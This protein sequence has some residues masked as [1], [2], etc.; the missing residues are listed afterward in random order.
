MIIHSGSRPQLLL[1]RPMRG[2]G[3]PMQADLHPQVLM[4]ELER[5][6]QGPSP[7][8]LTALLQTRDEGTPL[9]LISTQNDLSARLQ[10]ARTGCGIYLPYPV[11]LEAFAH[12]LDCYLD[13]PPP[14]PER[15]L[16]VEDSPVQATYLGT[17]L[18]EAGMETCLVTDPEQALDRL[19]EFKPDLILMD[20]T[21]W[22]F[23]SSSS[24]PRWDASGSSR[25]SARASMTS[26]R[27]PSSPT[28]SSLPSASAGIGPA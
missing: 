5:G 14:E 25:P 4:V 13:P 17:I 20:P 27:S 21:S 12:R 1:L 2:W 18:R 3:R 26:P 9:V 28:T 7:Q 11:N 23:P 10:S 24:A 22:A 16:I 8:G 19:G 6:E 15:V